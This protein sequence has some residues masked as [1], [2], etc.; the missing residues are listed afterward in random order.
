M[1]DWEKKERLEEKAQEIKWAIALI[2]CLMA[3]VIML[4]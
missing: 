4:H 2:I 1:I 3:L